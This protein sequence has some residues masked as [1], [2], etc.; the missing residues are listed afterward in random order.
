[1]RERGILHTLCRNNSKTQ[2]KEEVKKLHCDLVVADQF[3]EPYCQWQN[4]AEIKG[5]KNL[6]A[7]TQVIMDRVGA[8]P[9]LWYCCQKYLCEVHYHCAHSQNDWKSLEQV[10]RG[11][12]P[13]ISHFLQFYWYKPVLYKDT[14]PKFPHTKELPGHFVGIAKTLVMH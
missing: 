1:M 8:P 10:S 3:S 6:K 11:D 2:N 5:V 14:D 4:P 9:E 7:Q 12:T 13:D